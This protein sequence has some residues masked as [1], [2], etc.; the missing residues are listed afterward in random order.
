MLAARTWPWKRGRREK[1]E[2]L[3]LKT[4]KSL[5]A[6]KSSVSGGMWWWFQAV[7]DAGHR[8][9]QLKARIGGVSM[10]LT[11]NMWNLC[12]GNHGSDSES[13]GEDSDVIHLSSCWNPGAGTDQI[14]KGR[15]RHPE[16]CHQM[17]KGR[18]PHPTNTASRNGTFQ[19]HAGKCFHTAE[20]IYL[21]VSLWVHNCCQVLQLQNKCNI[22][23]LN[24]PAS[25]VRVTLSSSIL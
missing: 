5:P 23:Q 18:E 15:A 3:C 9:I 13:S 8:W 25:R 2:V 16:L 17:S 19:K 4:K 6:A 20:S 11:L 24:H 22:P 14:F 12:V 7:Q 21:E 10:Y 1:K